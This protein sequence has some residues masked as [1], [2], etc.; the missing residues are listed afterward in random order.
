IVVN[1]QVTP[2]F[3]QV[4][5]I[6]A[7]TSLSALPTTSSNG[8]I[9]TWSP[10]I[11]NQATTTYTFTPVSGSCA[12]TA[13]MTIVVNPQV[14]PTFTQVAPICAGASLSALPTTSS[15]GIIGTW[16]P[17]I[18]NQVTTTYTFTPVSGSCATTATMT[19]VVNSVSVPT[20]DAQQTFVEGATLADIVLSPS[21]GI[22]WYQN[23]NDAISNSNALPLS[24]V[25]I[26]ATV[27]YAVLQQ[28]NCFSEPF[29]VSVSVTLS[30]EDFSSNSI[31]IY[32]IP[33]TN[34]I[35]ISFEQN[36]RG[37]INLIDINGKVIIQKPIDKINMQLE[38]LG[39]LNQGLYLLQI[40]DEDGNSSTKKIIK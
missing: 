2:T 14:T 7:G 35:T 20:G 3:T 30:L 10:A 40:I 26:N 37:T 28:G 16:S 39:F 6:C 38:N 21:S 34:E 25:L 33:F 36:L 4:A 24:T 29:A 31:R 8:I 15:N 9:G 18:N 11:N 19:I 5:P 32:P 13:T 17:A 22:I 12:T 27:Y 1:P 23:L